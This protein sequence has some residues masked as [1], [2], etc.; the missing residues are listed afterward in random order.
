MNI[1]QLTAP[2]GGGGSRQVCPE[3]VHVARCYQI[4][5]LG[6]TEQGGNFPGK[7]RKVQF[8]FETPYE[9]AVFNEELGEQPYYVRNM[10]TL[11][12]NEKAILRKDVQSWTGKTM[13]D[14]EAQQFNIF[15]LIGKPCMINVVHA[16]KGE[17]TYANIKAITPLA[18]G[19]TCPEPINEALCFM[20]SMPDMEVF[21]KLPEFIQDKIKESDE[22][23]RYMEQGMEVQPPAPRPQQP[24][25]AA[26]APQGNPVNNFP[27]ASS[28]N[29][30]AGK[31]T[32]SFFDG[33]DD[34][35]PP[36]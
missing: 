33:M 25:A 28:Y 1:P 9:L 23:Q 29:P 20:A 15:S 16:T 31:Q 27:P 7:K 6:T 24:K 22:F 19:M 5:D 3:G 35:N 14:K 30:N 32:D 34:Q 12:M 18:K 13:S 21:G 8:L 4:I 26:P 36:F 2:V 10:Y 17:N 11:S